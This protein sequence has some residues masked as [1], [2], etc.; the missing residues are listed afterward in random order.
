MAV[1]AR[2]R[3]GA[4]APGETPGAP[5]ESRPQPVKRGVVI[6]PRTTS[7]LAPH[8]SFCGTL[9]VTIPGRRAVTTMRAIPRAFVRPVFVTPPPVTTTVRPLAGLPADVTRTTTVERLP[10]RSVPGLAVNRSHTSTFFTVRTTGLGTSVVA[11]EPVGTVPR[12]QLISRPPV[13]LPCVVDTETNAVPTGSGSASVTCVAA[14]GPL[15]PTT[16]V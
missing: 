15:F 7:C 3:A 10:T 11:V 6:A 16:I 5:A 8:L 13:Q 9:T 4:G 1:G 12:L 2:R 14:S